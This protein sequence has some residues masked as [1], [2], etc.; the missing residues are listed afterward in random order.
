MATKS[1]EV[2]A[3][4]IKLPPVL[5]GELATVLNVSLLL[6][7][8]RP[9]RPY[10]EGELGI[11]METASKFVE[12]PELRKQL[13]AVV[14]IGTS[15]TRAEIME[16]LK[17]VGYAEIKGKHIV[18][19][20]KGITL[21]AWLPSDLS[22]LE[23]TAVWEAYLE[24][25]AKGTGSRPDFEAGIASETARL[26]ELVKLL[27][28][29]PMESLRSTKRVGSGKPTVKQIDL[30]SKIATRLGTKLSADVLASFEVCSKFIEAHK[31]AF[32]PT[33]KQ[34]SYAQSLAKQHSTD[35]PD[36]YLADQRKLSD[37]IGKLAPKKNN[38]LK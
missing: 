12:N 33:P 35:I 1:V 17:S 24:S 26:I 30:A 2:T 4:D 7:K 23:R 37:W 8:T 32:P 22:S 25:I 9:P 34:I 21:I 13:K 38:G 20:E 18:P 27:P 28:P 6:R 3:D 11:E 19:T 10:T 29:F 36:G 16:T 31:D 15:A 14:G 5:D